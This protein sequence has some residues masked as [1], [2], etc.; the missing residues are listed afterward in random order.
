M[1]NRTV[2]KLILSPAFLLFLKQVDLIT[3]RV[4]ART[5]LSPWSCT[6]LLL[7]DWLLEGQISV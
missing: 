3:L 1:R 6:T 5:A 2:V 7:R 4:F